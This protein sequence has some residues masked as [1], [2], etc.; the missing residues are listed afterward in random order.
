MET[1]PPHTKSTGYVLALISTLPYAL[2]I[3]IQRKV[4]ARIRASF[5]DSGPNHRW[6]WPRS[7]ALPVRYPFSR[8]FRQAFYLETSPKLVAIFAKKR[9]PLQSRR[10]LVR[11]AKNCSELTS[12]A[13][14][15]LGLR[16]S[17][18]TY[19]ST[20]WDTFSLISWCNTPFED[21]REHFSKMLPAFFCSLIRDGRKRLMGWCV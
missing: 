8:H 2:F 1:F 18:S 9:P 12:D 11:R 3:S 20:L 21:G 6:F 7:C 16:V 10:C 14:S 4:S 5:P 17:F 13:S 19:L 15:A